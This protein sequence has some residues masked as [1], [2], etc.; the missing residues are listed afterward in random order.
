MKRKNN[1]KTNYLSFRGSKVFFRALY[2]GVTKYK[3]EC[4]AK[5]KDQTNQIFDQGLCRNILTSKKLI[6]KEN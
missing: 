1:N 2:N 3:H 6:K 5:K 4:I